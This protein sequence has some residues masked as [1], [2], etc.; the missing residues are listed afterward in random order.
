MDGGPEEGQRGTGHHFCWKTL[1]SFSVHKSMESSLG[2]KA[3]FLSGSAVSQK[4]I[5]HS[6]QSS[7]DGDKLSHWPFTIKSE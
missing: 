2:M 5:Q 6:L 4:I 7:R 3:N 1:S